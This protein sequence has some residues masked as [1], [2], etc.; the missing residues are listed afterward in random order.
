MSTTTIIPHQIFALN[1]FSNNCTFRK[2]QMRLA[3]LLSTLLILLC[4]QQANDSF[5]QTTAS[6]PAN[7]TS[8][9]AKET[10]QDRDARM[11]WWQEGKFGMFV[12]WGVYS[13]TGGL[14]K[15]QK[16]PNSAE[17]MMCRG[18]IPIAEYE[19]LSLIHI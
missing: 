4:V 16:L 3:T 1:C 10:E 18:K 17:W 13:T 6:A 15:G 11:R 14:Y 8:E 2:R 7:A 19:K 5:G 12:H 9:Q